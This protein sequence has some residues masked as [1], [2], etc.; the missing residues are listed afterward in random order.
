MIC[1][2][3]SLDPNV[4]PDIPALLSASAALSISGLPFEGPI[5]AARVGYRNGE[6]ILNPSFNDLD[7]SKLDLVVA[8]T[9]SSVLMVESEADCLPE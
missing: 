2:V 9:K 4:D 8:G 3:I 7:D 5:G 1:T 6:Y